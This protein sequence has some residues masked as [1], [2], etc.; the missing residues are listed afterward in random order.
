MKDSRER[1]MSTW[2]YDDALLPGSVEISV[3]V[4]I[5]ECVQGHVEHFQEVTL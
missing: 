2:S 3:E 5:F 1:E 4:V